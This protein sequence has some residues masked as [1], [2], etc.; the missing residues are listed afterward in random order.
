MLDAAGKTVQEKLQSVVL[1]TTPS[2]VKIIFDYMSKDD[3]VAGDITEVWEVGG[4]QAL[5][6]QY[7]TANSKVLLFKGTVSPG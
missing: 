2:D 1:D 6:P 5:V 7:G 4:N 3:G